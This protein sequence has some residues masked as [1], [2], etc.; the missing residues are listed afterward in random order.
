MNNSISSSTYF[1][2]T[3]I[4]GIVGLINRKDLFFRSQKYNNGNRLNE[5]E[6][7]DLLI[8]LKHALSEK[9]ISK[10]NFSHRYQRSIPIKL[11]NF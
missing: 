6:F 5:K 7:E 1:P 4:F 2:A 9:I 3:I 10:P 8:T 11:K